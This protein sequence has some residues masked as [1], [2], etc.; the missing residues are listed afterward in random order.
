MSKPPAR[1]S[2]RALLF[3]IL[4]AP[5]PARAFDPVFDYI[6]TTTP[7][8]GLAILHR[9]RL[10]YE[11]YFGRGH[12][13]AAPNLASCGKSVTGI[14]L[15]IHFGVRGLDERAVR[16]L[17]EWGADRREIRLGHL[18]A[19]SAGI[20]GNNPCFVR[21]REV[22]IDPPG[23]DGWQAMVDATALAVP[24]WCEPGG[25]Y[26][27]ATASCHVASIILRRASGMELESFVRERLAKPLGWERW[28]WGYRQHALEH[29]PG[30]GG[31]ALRA[32]DMLSFGQLLLEEGRG[33]VPR[34]YVRLCSRPSPFNPHYL[35]SL[36]FNVGGPEGAFWKSGSGGHCLYVVPRLHLVAFK[37]GGRGEQYEERN[38]GLPAAPK[39]D[40]PDPNFK[41]AVPADE[42][43]AQTL[44]RIVAIVKMR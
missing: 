35:Y 19:M 37:L 36:Q 44:R 15:G 14:A 39:T 34:E 5:I 13:E 30:G 6:R 16:Y 32:R 40:E 2:R 8:G 20:R 42:A 18:L 1:P 31:I 24:L 43:A 26:S 4:S 21:S 29:T 22:R 25:G 3:G 38:T 11:R 28:G 41:P 10:V 27:Y 33:I 9:G 12:R 7:N 17:P 23:P